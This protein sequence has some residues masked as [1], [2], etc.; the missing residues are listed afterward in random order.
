MNNPC[1]VKNENELETVAGHSEESKDPYP[2]DTPDYAVGQYSSNKREWHY[3]GA[4][5][6]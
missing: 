5:G 2:E 4:L 3:G 1:L 6:A